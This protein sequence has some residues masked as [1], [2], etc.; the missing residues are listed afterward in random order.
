MTRLNRGDAPKD[1]APVYH[2]PQCSNRFTTQIE[3][4]RCNKTNEAPIYTPGDIIR[5]DVGYGW[6][7][8]AEHWLIPT[9]EHDNP[10]RMWDAYFIVTSVDH[11]EHQC[12][13]SVKTL[14]I[15]SG[16]ETGLCGWT[17]S[18]HYIGKKSYQ[19]ALAA[20]GAKYIGEKYKELL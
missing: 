2:C 9:K 1:F 13:Y 3:A 12:R 5:I 15:K 14:G 10:R 18:R 7:D 8:G 19:P 17:S 20:E 11:D 16:D 6:F 4:I